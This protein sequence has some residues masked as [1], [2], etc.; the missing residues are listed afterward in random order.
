[1]KPRPL[2]RLILG[3]ALLTAAAGSY[4][5]DFSQA[6]T[7]INSIKPNIPYNTF[8]A[9]TPSGEDKMAC[10]IKS[11][12]TVG[13]LVCKKDDYDGKSCD[14]L[15]KEETDNLKATQRAGLT[16]VTFK[17]ELLKPLKCADSASTECG[18][19]LTSWVSQGNFVN[20][21]DTI[22]D[23]HVVE[24][25]NSI[26]R[27]STSPAALAKTRADLKK[28]ADF[29]TASGGK[30]SRVCDLQGFYLR[31]GGFLIND[32]PALKLNEKTAPNCWDGMPTWQQ[33]HDG[34]E[35]LIRLLK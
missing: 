12:P 32:V 14:S 23:G 1:M 30:Y 5:D 33:A 11:I 13:L 19:Y 8:C 24:L 25:A 2:C 35:Q 22:H 28:I 27:Y 31:S 3:A 4:A 26:Q 18:G 6:R 10:Q 7:K 21:D 15:I 34:L 17:P 16:T 9:S 20:I 29:M